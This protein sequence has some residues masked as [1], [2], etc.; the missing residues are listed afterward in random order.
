MPLH[1]S[2]VFLYFFEKGDLK[3]THNF[4]RGCVHFYALFPTVAVNNSP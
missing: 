4:C 2:D 3:S 1:Y